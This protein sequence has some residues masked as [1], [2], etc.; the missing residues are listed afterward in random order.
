MLGWHRHEPKPLP[1]DQVVNAGT[2]PQPRTSPEVPAR[3]RKMA[4]LAVLVVGAIL[5]LQQVIQA[6]FPLGDGGLFYATIDQIR[7]AGGLPAV[8]VYNGE[9]PLV[10]PP[11]G[12]VVGALASALPGVGTEAVLRIQPALYAVA[13]LALVAWCA[14]RI[15][16][17][18]VTG[19]VAG[20]IVAVMPQS[21]DQLVAGGGVTRGLGMLL[22]LAA[23]GAAAGSPSSGR[24]GAIVGLLLGLTALAHPQVAMFGL[25]SVAFV[26]WW[27]RTALSR[28]EILA[29]MAVAAICIIPWFALLATR[30]QLDALIAGGQRADVVAGVASLLLYPGMQAMHGGIPNVGVSLALVGVAACLFNRR[31]SILLWLLAVHILNCPPFVSAVAWGIAG[32]VGIVEILSV[33]QANPAPK[34]A[35]ALPI[36]LI[37]LVAVLSASASPTDPGSKQQSLLPE[38]VESSRR[39]AELPDGARLAVVTSETWGNDLIGEWLPTLS[40]QTVITTPQGSEWLGV[41]AF[42]Q[43]VR[44]HRVTE[45]CSR[46][47]ANCIASAIERGELDATHIVIPR[48]SVSGPRGP[49][50]CCPALMETIREDTRFEIVVDD[51]GVL[52]AAWR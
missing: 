31:W 7:E 22:A 37:A 39:L 51:P 35:I 10:Y 46:Q 23:I 13:A 47:T 15:T 28:V 32:A 41:A 21:Y 6:D 42:D 16:N 43:R 50:D 27:R 26:W 1:L 49:D 36:S 33:V 19:I 34:R 4:L 8:I 2:R 45:D 38:Q 44:A 14:A 29:T 18:P 11:L 24:R 12:F 9:I 48:G 40:G 30:G 25:V 5:R 52:V 3:D 17:N 20:A